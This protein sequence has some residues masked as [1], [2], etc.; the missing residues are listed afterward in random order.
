MQ[1][2]T[3]QWITKRHRLAAVLS[4]YW[5]WYR[6][7]SLLCYIPSKM[8]QLATFRRRL[9]SLVHWLPAMTLLHPWIPL[10]NLR[11]HSLFPRVSSLRRIDPS[12]NLNFQFPITVF[13]FWRKNEFQLLDPRARIFW[14]H[15]GSQKFR[16]TTMFSYA[17]VDRSGAAI[18]DM[19]LAHTLAFSRGLKY[20]GACPRRA[21][22]LPKTRVDTREKLLNMIGVDFFVYSK[23]PRGAKM[24]E[25]VDYY[26]KPEVF[27]RTTWITYVPPQHPRLASTA[28]VHQ[29]LPCM[30]AEG[31]SHHAAKMP[32]VTFRT[33]TFWHWLKVTPKSF[34]SKSTVQVST[35]LQK[36]LKWLDI[37]SPNPKNLLMYSGSLVM[38]LCSTDL[39]RMF[40]VGLFSIRTLSSSCYRVSVWCRGCFF[41]HCLPFHRQ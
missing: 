9:E 30:F 27:S 14:I 7:S 19:L 6:L 26:Q 4:K 32:F 28:H 2:Q 34:P 41:L 38:K 10:M 5:F 29:E 39:F 21:A 35:I 11:V 37:Q 18:H 8:I 20:A 15:Y 17:R 16:P 1:A 12:M 36:K 40:G 31:T 3:S 22:K 33:S 24:V 23:C 13:Q 25:G